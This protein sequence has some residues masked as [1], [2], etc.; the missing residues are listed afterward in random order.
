MSQVPIDYATPVEPAERP[1]S[2]TVLAIIGILYGA[3]MF[4]C[5]P[6]SIIPYFMRLPQPN[7]V[8]DLTKNDPLLFAWTV[9]AAVVG[10]LLSIIL[11]SGSI[12]ALGLRE[13]ARQFL[14]SWA[15]MSILVA[16]GQIVFSLVYAQPRM[17]QA[18]ASQ[19]N[20]PAVAM[21]G[22]WTIVAMI[23]GFVIGFGW[24]IA[25]LFFMTRRKVKDAFA[26]GLRRAL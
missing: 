17:Q 9:A 4:L 19:A 11:L 23:V 8:I 12:G 13:W 16:A 10:W 18:L 24:P 1:V 6:M 7:P 5:T 14:V 2:V 25:M 26:R 21:A 20:N 15:I 3:L 22:I